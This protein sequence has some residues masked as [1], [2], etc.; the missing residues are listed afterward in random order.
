M[1]LHSFEAASRKD[2]TVGD[3]WLIDALKAENANFPA[4]L[5]IPAAGPPQTAQRDYKLKQSYDELQKEFQELRVQSAEALELP[6]ELNRLNTSLK[7]QL[8]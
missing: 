8:R 3:A 7:I 2:R 5:N 4:A 1:H 6:Q